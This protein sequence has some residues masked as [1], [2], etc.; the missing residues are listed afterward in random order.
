MIYEEWTYILLPVDLV[1]IDNFHIPCVLALPAKTH[2]VLIIHANA[3]L[4]FAIAMQLLQMIPRWVS[5]IVKRFGKINCFDFPG[6]CSGD[7]SKPPAFPGQVELSRFLIGEGPDH[8]ENRITRRVKRLP[9][10][11]PRYSFW[12]CGHQ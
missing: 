5:E 1:V 4:S 3:V 10:S 11:V 6:R 2:P 9:L 7:I 12:H 8:T